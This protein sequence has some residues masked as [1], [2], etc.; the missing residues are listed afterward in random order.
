[1]PRL[2]IVN[3]DDL[4]YDPAVDR[5]ILEAATRGIVTSATL[6]VNTAFSVRS[7]AGAK[8]AP[9][10]ALGL[11]LN[12]ARGESLSKALSLLGADG[13]LAEERAA[14]VTPEDAAAEAVAQLARFEA[15]TG[16]APTHLDVHK[17]LHRHPGIFAGVAQVARQRKLPLR[18]IDDAMRAAV[19]SAGLATPDAFIG[20]T[21][22]EAYWSPGKLLAA[23]DRL[24]EG[25]TELMCHPGYRPELTRT[26]YGVQREGE[27]A[28][29]VDPRVVERCRGAELR[30]VTFAALH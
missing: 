21:G 8:A 12:F 2:L 28:A 19:R 29:L 14:T 1:M 20:D 17:H 23:L 3:A 25:I 16:K 4:G 18:A 24:G 26:S 6:M 5:G 27:L 15:L 10:L 30:L 13:G 9:A 22:V 11:H 7:A